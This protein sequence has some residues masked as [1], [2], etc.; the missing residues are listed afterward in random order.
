MEVVER[1]SGVD[2]D[3]SLLNYLLTI[4]LATGLGI[5]IDALSK[6]EKFSYLKYLY[7]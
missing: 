5:V 7:S 6:K 4:T 1:L 3:N 2:L